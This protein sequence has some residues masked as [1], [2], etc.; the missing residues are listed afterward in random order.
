MIDF[1][2]LQNDFAQVLLG[3]EWLRDIN[4][5]TRYKL[6]LDDVKRPDRSLAVETLAYLTPRNGRKGVGIIVE[7]PEVQVLQEIVQ[8]PEVQEEHIQFQVHQ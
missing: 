1:V 7:V 2:A 5:V 8:V 3:D 4:V 6:L